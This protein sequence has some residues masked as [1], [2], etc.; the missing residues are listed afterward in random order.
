MTSYKEEKRK[1]N[2][3]NTWIERYLNPNTSTFMNHW[4]VEDPQ[5]KEEIVVVR[6]IKRI[7]TV[8]SRTQIQDRTA[9]NMWC[10]QSR[11]KRES[12]RRRTEGL[13]RRE[14]FLRNRNIQKKKKCKSLW[15]CVV[16][17]ER[18]LTQLVT[19]QFRIVTCQNW[20]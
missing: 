2:D 17:T 13:K 8:G 3:V 12:K 16:P 9:K 11:T 5:E 18:E 10:I 6:R 15:V 4:S 19:C 1:R 20:P 14:D 7:I